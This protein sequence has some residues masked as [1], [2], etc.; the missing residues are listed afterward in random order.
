MDPSSS[1]SFHSLPSFTLRK[2]EN[3][4]LRERSKKGVREWEMPFTRKM[5]DCQ[6]FWR[7]RSPFSPSTAPSAR[8]NGSSERKS[9]FLLL[10]PS[11][12]SRWSGPVCTCDPFGC[13]RTLPAAKRRFCLW[14]RFAL[15]V[16][17]HC[18]PS[19]SYCS[20]SLTVRHSS[21]LAFTP[22]LL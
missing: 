21:S 9:L 13:K 4:R 20:P 8:I 6:S 2:E 14:D 7:K 16:L 10:L 15:L 12:C 3:V 1:P 19:S 18:M 11:T 5:N 22:S 17:R